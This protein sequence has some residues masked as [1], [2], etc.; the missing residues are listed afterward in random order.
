MC[1]A[2]S[3]SWAVPSDMALGATAIAASVR[4][5]LPMWQTRTGGQ[6]GTG[7]KSNRRLCLV[8]ELLL[9][10]QVAPRQPEVTT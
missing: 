5:L 9:G 10:S 2:G 6:S 8:V 7:K 1:V 3:R 4:L